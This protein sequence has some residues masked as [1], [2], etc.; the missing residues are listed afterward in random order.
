MDPYALRARATEN[1]PQNTITSL[2]YKLD[3]KHELTDQ[4]KDEI[5]AAVQESLTPSGAVTV[6]DWVYPFG[7]IM[8][9]FWVEISYG[10]I[11]SILAPDADTIKRAMK[12]RR[13]VKVEKWI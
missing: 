1:E 9:E 4:E 5:F 3:E 6:K 7:S 2:Y 13:V 10:T 12:P 8:P 11:V